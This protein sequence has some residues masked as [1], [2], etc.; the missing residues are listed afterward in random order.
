MLMLTLK[1][2]GLVLCLFFWQVVWAFDPFIVKDIRIEGL[3]RISE[4]KVY[5]AFPVTTGDLFDESLSE[6]SIKALYASGYFHNIQ[7]GREGDV[8]VIAV[9]ERPAINDIVIE[10]NSDLETDPLLDSLKEIGFAKG[11]VFNRSILDKVE[12]ELRRQYFSRGKYSVEI[13][14]E[15]TPLEDNRVNVRLDI[16]E[17]VIA[18]IRQINIVGNKVFEDDD[19]L[20]TFQLSTPNLWSFYTKRDQYSK[21]KLSGDLE[22]LRS[23]YQDRGFIRFNV[24]STQV[25]ISPDKKDIYVTIN[26]TEGDK[27]T[28][29]EVRLSGD[30][31]FPA[32]ELFPEVQTNAG[33]VFSRKDATR[34]IDGISKKLGGQGF[35][36]ANINMMPEVDEEKHEVKLTFVVDPGKRVYV[37]RINFAGNTK[38]RDI[39]LRQEMRQ[40]E[41]GWFSNQQVERSRT[42]LQRLG[43]FEDVNV[44]TPAVPGTNDQVDVN[45]SIAEQPSASISAGVGFSQTSGL[46]LNAS[47]TQDNFLGTGK[48]VSL[49]IN[50]SSVNR[51]FSFNYSNPY[52]TVDG[53]SRGFGLYYRTTDAEEANITNYTTDSFGGN[54]NYGFPINEYDRINFG[55]NA[56]HLKLKVQE[57]ASSEVKEFVAE[58][59]STFNNYGISLS[60]SHDTRNRRVFPTK[61]GL[62]SISG[63]VKLPAS[64]LE[65]YK[66]N[67]REQQYI[68]LTKDFVLSL[69]A[70]LNSGDGYGDLRKLPFF[71]NYFGGGV[72]SVRGYD[73]NTLGPRDDTNDP[74]GS[75]FRTIFNAEI[76]FPPP[77]VEKTNALRLGVFFDAGNVFT[78]A[79]AFDVDGLRT[80]V[81]VSA[82]WLSPIGPFAISLAEPLNDKPGDE[83]RLFQFTIG[84]PF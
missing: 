61:G 3:Q 49:A 4:G 75:G 58:N 48:H 52:Y 62:H 22:A 51:I 55:I 24:D 16:S 37:R 9:T 12:Q 10:G 45:F 72:R 53:V 38:T 13:E 11:G 1:R 70:R 59:G 74:I 83:T 21:Q 69:K 42:R 29:S 57:F 66:L 80:S 26:I 7:L 71:E 47:V 19:L 2:L 6:K 23:F 79:N 41:A 8:L 64:D 50:S 84:V 46:L 40:M 60:W 68:P 17:G 56:E 5:N 30:L 15:I 73:D 27:Y 43:Y 82:V 44:E 20:K 81:G 14:P 54:L 35:A 18:R 34:T 28:V 31:K 63:E 78:S 76:L 33:D 67:V 36:F 32:K 25:S 65:Y 39:V 77:F